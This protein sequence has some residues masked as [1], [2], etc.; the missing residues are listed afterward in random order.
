MSSKKSRQKKILTSESAK[1]NAFV[2]AMATF[3]YTNYM[4]D[5][6]DGVCDD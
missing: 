4:S 3:V 5:M 2:M 1:W 6:S